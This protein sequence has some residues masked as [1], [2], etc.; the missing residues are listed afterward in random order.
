VTLSK[1]KQVTAISFFCSAI[2][3]IAFA[4]YF[5]F[6]ALFNPVPFYLSLFLCLRLN[7]RDLSVL[8]RRRP[9][10]Q[11]VLQHFQLPHPTAATTTILVPAHLQRNRS[12]LFTDLLLVL[13]FRHDLPFAP[14]PPT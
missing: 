3:Q 6:F 4:C 13:S 1:D 10:D 11:V 12:R 2:V 9:R 14:C 7:H 5:C 8:R